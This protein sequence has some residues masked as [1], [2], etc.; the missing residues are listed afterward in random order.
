[1]ISIYPIPDLTFIDK[2]IKDRVFFIE[3]SGAADLNA[4]QACSIESFARLHPDKSIYVLMISEEKTLNSNMETKMLKKLYKNVTFIRLD[5]NDYIGGSPLEKFYYCN[6]DWRQDPRRADHL[7]DGLR[8]LTLY[9]YGGYYFDMDFL[10]FRPVPDYKR[11]LVAQSSTSLT[12][13]AIHY[14]KAQSTLFKMALA[15]FTQNFK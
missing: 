6:K 4:R 7:S 13:S 3:S 2:E 8:L 9:N 5:L 14:D 15:E 10:F 11:F 12:N 1:M